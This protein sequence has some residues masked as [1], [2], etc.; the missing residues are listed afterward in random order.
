MSRNERFDWTDELLEKAQYL[1]AQGLTWPKVAERLGCN[2]KH[3]LIILNKKK[4]GRR[5]GYKEPWSRERIYIETATC[6]GKTPREIAENLAKARGVA[7]T[8]SS[9]STVLSKMA[10]MGFDLEERAECMRVTATPEQDEELAL[11]LLEITKKW[12]ESD[13]I[14]RKS[15]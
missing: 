12:E 13:G 10:R 3:L 6:V 2:W 9:H 15:I 5:K 1:K 4:N 14:K 7:F 8:R 11:L